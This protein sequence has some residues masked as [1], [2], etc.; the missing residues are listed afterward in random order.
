MLQSLLKTEIIRLLPKWEK[1][2]DLHPTSW[3]TKYMTFR[4][5]TCNTKIG[6]I[7]FNVQLA[8]RTPECLEYVILHEL[9]HLIEKSHNERFVSFMDKYMPMWR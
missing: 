1:I 7:W 2:T 9:I 3:Q 4:W 5:G 8:K 6:K